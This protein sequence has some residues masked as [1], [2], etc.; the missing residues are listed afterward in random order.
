VVVRI[1]ILVANDYS[2]SNPTA[3]LTGCQL[4]WGGSREKERGNIQQK[5]NKQLRKMKI[6][7]A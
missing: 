2:T 1:W 7:E 3:V 5:K 4:G 6:E